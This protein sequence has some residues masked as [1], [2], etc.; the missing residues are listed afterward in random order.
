LCFSW[1]HVCV[2]CCVTPQCIMTCQ[3]QAPQLQQPVGVAPLPDLLWNEGEQLVGE[4]VRRKKVA[5]VEL[6]VYRI[7]IYLDALAAANALAAFAGQPYDTLNSQQAF[8]DCFVNGRFRKT[9]HFTFLR[10][11][12]KAKLQTAWN[13][14]LLAR[15]GHD[16]AAEVENFA[17]IMD[18]AAEGDVLTV[19]FGADGEHVEVDASWRTC[20]SCVVKSHAVWLCIQQTYFDRD[21]EFLGLKLGA[22]RH[23]PEI[24]FDS[25]HFL[26]S[27][28]S[29]SASS[30]EGLAPAEDAAGSALHHGDYI[31]RTSRSRKTWREYACRSSGKDGYKFGDIT[32]GVLAKSRN[33]NQPSH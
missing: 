12:P 3:K 23:L 8:F 25:G 20:G 18:S 17:A 22:I 33:L 13:A 29:T 26:E 16:A 24:I 6:P 30:N 21:S 7:A 2:D 27:C 28:R 10:F 15:A 5:S 31:Q 19:R 9:M 1:L 11:L 32:R 4:G 14:Q